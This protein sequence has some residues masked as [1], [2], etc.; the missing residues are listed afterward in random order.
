[1]RGHPTIQRFKADNCFHFESFGILASSLAT[2]PALE[3]I[4]LGHEELG[5]E[6]LQPELLEDLPAIV[7]PEH[8]TTLLLSPSLRS[9]NLMNST[10][11]IQFVKQSRSP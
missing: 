11:Q 10:Y 8:I 4:V 6:Q 2:L 7:H 1:M 3:S 9:I 5:N